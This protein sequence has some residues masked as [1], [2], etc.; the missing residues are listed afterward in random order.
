MTATNSETSPYHVMVR[1]VHISLGMGV[2]DVAVIESILL[3][4]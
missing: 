4:F 2:G 1:S 3:M